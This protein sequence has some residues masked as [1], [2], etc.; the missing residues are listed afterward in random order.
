METE[1][2]KIFNHQWRTGFLLGLLWIVGGLIGGAVLGIITTDPVFYLIGFATGFI[3]VFLL[4]S[5]YKYGE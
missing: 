1:S 2:R 3:A 4:T 5:Y